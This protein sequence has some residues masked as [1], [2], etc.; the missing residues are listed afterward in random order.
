MLFT[1]EALD[2]S[3]GDCLILHHGTAAHPAFVLIDGGPAR[4]YNRSLLPRLRQLRAALG[5]APREPLPLGL[6]VPHPRRRRSH[7]RPAQALRGDL[8]RPRR[9]AARDHPGRGAVAQQLRRRARQPVPFQFYRVD[10]AAA[11]S[12]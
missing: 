4:T 2:A 1:I 12:R 9:E 11:P 10:T 7:R 5:L 8:R 6:V 3:E